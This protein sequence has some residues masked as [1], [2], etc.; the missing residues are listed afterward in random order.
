MRRA[1]GAGGGRVPGLLRHPADA[2]GP[3]QGGIPGGGAAVPERPG[4]RPGHG[5]SHHPG[6]DPP[7]AGGGGVGRRAGDCPEPG[8]AL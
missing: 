4:Y 7:G 6:D 8:A 3:G 5:P 1:D 2:E